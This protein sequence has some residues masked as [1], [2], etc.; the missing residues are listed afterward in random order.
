VIEGVNIPPRG[1]SSP[2]GAKFTPEGK[3]ML[4]KTGLWYLLFSLPDPF[5]C[6]QPVFGRQ[7][8]GPE[9][10][11]A[12]LSNSQ[13]ELI[14]VPDVRKIWKKVFKGGCYYSMNIFA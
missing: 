7:V 1:Q 13:N 10:F 8:K 4:L 14:D 6:L 12:N 2:L 5:E 3:L 9:T 11:L